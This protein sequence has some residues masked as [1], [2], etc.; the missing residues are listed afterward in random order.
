MPAKNASLYIDQAVNS[1]RKVN[2]E[3]WEL[4]V[5][6][7]HSI[8]DTYSIIKRAEETDS[9]IKVFKNKGTGKVIGLNYGY[10]FTTGEIIKCIDADD[11]L[12]E[13]FFDYIDMMNNCDAFC[14]NYYVAASDLRILG[15][16]SMDKSI[17]TKDFLYCLKY[18]KS[19]PRC[20]WS[21]VRQ[22][23]DKIFP[24]P[25]NL[26]FED[27]WFSLIIKKYA[28][29]ICH[30]NDNLYYYRQHNNQ[31]F[32]GVLNFNSEVVSFRA[33]RMLEFIDVITHEE[34]KRLVS[35]INNTAFF[36]T[37]RLFYGL[38]ARDRV[39]LGEIVKLDIPLEFRLKLFFYKKLNF[40]TPMIVRSKWFIDKRR[41]VTTKTRNHLITNNKPGSV[42]CTN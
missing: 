33:L 10:T 36:D 32:G 31:V 21:F 17:L 35:G 42:D 12:S 23:G 2:Y 40:L 11:I 38:L 39:S 19:L 27:V 8:D 1:L 6:D 25:D 34:T 16:Y 30:I 28:Q 29:R 24:M 18:L 26:P 7:D 4:I 22:L 13:K 41:G 5:I 15:H 9:R 37:M 20:T 14:H 3:N